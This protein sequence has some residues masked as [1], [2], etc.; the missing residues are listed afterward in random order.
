MI[1][2]A[3]TIS[4]PAERRAGCLEASVAWQQATR[5]DEPGCLAY[6]FAAD[7]V[8]DAVISVYELW[9]GPDNLEAHF[10]HENYWAMRKVFAEHGITG[11]SVQKFRTDA[12][13]PVYGS[14]GVATARF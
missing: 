3:G 9:D 12:V 14:D 5:R 4:I 11:A 2:I 1:V 10:V 13:A 7:P 6:V 8:D